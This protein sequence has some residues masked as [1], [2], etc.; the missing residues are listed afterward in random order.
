[1]RKNGEIIIIGVIFSTI[2]I[3]VTVIRDSIFLAYLKTAT[4]KVVI[5][6]LVKNVTTKEDLLRLFFLYQEEQHG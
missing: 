1:M 6:K 3:L 5:D 4:D 2:F